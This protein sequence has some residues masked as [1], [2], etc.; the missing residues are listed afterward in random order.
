GGKPVVIAAEGS[1][2]LESA[3][4]VGFALLH[5]RIVAL[6]HSRD[7]EEDGIWI[8]YPAVLADRSCDLVLNTLVRESIGLCSRLLIG[9]RIDPSSPEDHGIGGIVLCD[10]WHVR[11]QTRILG[12]D[13]KVIAPRNIEEE[14]LR[15]GLE[16]ARSVC[17]A[18]IEHDAGGQPVDEIDPDG[19]HQDP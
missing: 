4:A 11:A 7:D 10:A 19:V 12:Q 13:V 14:L 15:Q 2:A 5:R 17:Y 9:L 6:E 1:E 16:V 3:I 8:R 18:R